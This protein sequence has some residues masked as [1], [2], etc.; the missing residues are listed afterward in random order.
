MIKYPAYKES[1]FGVE[2]EGGE[3]G[4]D[5]DDDVTVMEGVTSGLSVRNSLTLTW[6]EMYRGSLTNVLMY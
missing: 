5:E 2:S 1:L 6:L 4:V 3:E